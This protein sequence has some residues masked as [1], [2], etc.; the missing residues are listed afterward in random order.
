MAVEDYSCAV[1]DLQRLVQLHS[2]SKEATARLRDAQH[3]LHV[4]GSAG[5]NYYTVL[6]LQPGCST[7]DVKAAYK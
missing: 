7:A 6:G 1:A 3:K 4:H 5:L 2:G